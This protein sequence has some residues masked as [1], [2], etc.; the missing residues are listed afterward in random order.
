MIDLLT[1][2]SSLV[3]TCMELSLYFE[4]IRDVDPASAIFGKEILDLKAV[5][6]RIRERVSRV[7]STI[8]ILQ[9]GQGHW[10]YV[11]I[12]LEDCKGTLDAL[13]RLVRPPIRV[14]QFAG[15][16]VRKKDE[17]DLDWNSEDIRLLQRQ[18]TSCRQTMGLSL[19]MMVV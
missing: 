12:S 1:P 4:R 16:L 9:S 13:D 8:L 2:L 11:A 5:L 15:F 10:E 7:G 18:V 6:S 14:L 17:I 3:Q 19:Q